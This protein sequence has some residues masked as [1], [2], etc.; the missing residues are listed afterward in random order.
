MPNA[1]KSRVRLGSLKDRGAVTA[2]VLQR[3]PIYSAQPLREARGYRRRR[4]RRSI[5][6]KAAPANNAKPLVAVAGSI[7]GTAT[8]VAEA[9]PA[10]PTTIMVTLLPSKKS[11][12]V[13]IAF[14]LFTPLKQCQFICGQA[15]TVRSNSPNLFCIRPSVPEIRLERARLV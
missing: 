14:I 9:V 4:R 1:A 6:S 15:R 10:S 3:R 5:N 7:S 13:V 8:A 12:V 11:R 2:R